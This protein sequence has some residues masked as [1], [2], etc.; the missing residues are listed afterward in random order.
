MVECSIVGRWYDDRRDLGIGAK[1]WYGIVSSADGKKL[2]AVCFN[3]L[4]YVSWD[5][6]V[7]W[8]RRANLRHW[9]NIASSADGNKL[10]ASVY[11]GHVWTSP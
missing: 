9:Y 1:D 2:A 4:I 3:N 7:S 6:G 8:T 5:A 10:A 11:N